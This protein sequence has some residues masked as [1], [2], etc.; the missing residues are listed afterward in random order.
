MNF[1]PDHSIGRD[2]RSEPNKGPHFEKFHR[3]GG[4]ILSDRRTN[5]AQFGANLNFRALFIKAHKTGRSDNG[6]IANRF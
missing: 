1:K 3:L 2:V 5:V 4:R 6:R